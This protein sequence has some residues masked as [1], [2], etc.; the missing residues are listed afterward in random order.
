MPLHVPTPVVVALDPLIIFS[1]NVTKNWLGSI[2]VNGWFGLAFDADGNFWFWTRTQYGPNYNYNLYK[3]TWATNIIEL[4]AQ[5]NNVADLSLV[6]G[7]IIT[8][9]GTI[10]TLVSKTSV[11]GSA[12]KYRLASCGTISAPT[13]PDLDDYIWSSES[14]AGDHRLY[15]VFIDQDDNIYGYCRDYDCFVKRTGVTTYELALAKSIWMYNTAFVGRHVKL[16]NDLYITDEYGPLL[17]YANID[18][19][20]LNM[21]FITELAHPF[22]WSDTAIC[23]NPTDGKIYVVFEDE[24]FHGEPEEEEFLSFHYFNPQIL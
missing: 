15:D 18:P 8:S 17:K 13:A 24:I 4:K 16:G 22:I 21:D 6:D 20:I 7:M 1:K 11:T 9:D 3:L 10:Y 12:W 5:Y 19:S 14:W 2:E 23:Y